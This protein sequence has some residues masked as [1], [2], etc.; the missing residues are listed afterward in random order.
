MGSAGNRQVHLEWHVRPGS[1]VAGYKPYRGLASGEE[2][3]TPIYEV[4]TT[5]LSWEWTDTDVRNGTQYF[6]LVRYIDTSQ[7]PV[8][9]A[10]SNEASAIPSN[11]SSARAHLRGEDDDLAPRRPGG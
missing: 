2:E 6:Y 10:P 1:P 7:P 9:S 5:D 8:F 4:T 11:L 3:E